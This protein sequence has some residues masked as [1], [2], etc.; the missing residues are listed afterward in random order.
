MPI[1]LM[2]TIWADRNGVH[3]AL[4]SP[5]E[6]VAWL[7]AVDER[8]D[9]P[10]RDLGPWL[11]RATRRDLHQLNLDLRR[12]R[13]AARRLA[14]RRTD[15]TRP[16]AQVDLSVTDAVVALNEYAAT[17]QTWPTLEWPDT[18]GPRSN[19]VT[20]ATPGSAVVGGLA[21]ATITLL[22]RESSDAL[23]ACQAPGCVLYFLKHHPRREWCSAACG[24]R[25][26]QARH[27][28]RH[29]G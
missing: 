14:A 15:D 22:T 8:E 18:G 29:R 6:A 25:A 13:D 17:A 23:R 2:N 19:V 3:E 7:R 12:L 10:V 9:A 5:S 20:A 28:R 26:R 24:N 4:G 11:E 16:A 21:R 27:Y 1:E